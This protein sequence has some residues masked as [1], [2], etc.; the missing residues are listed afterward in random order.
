MWA[1]LVLEAA[2]KMATC[3]LS[4]FCSHLCPWR[5][6][7][8]SQPPPPPGTSPPEQVLGRGRGTPPEVEQHPHTL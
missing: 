4:Q 8:P 3:E 5:S 1:S 7:L 6:A 2:I